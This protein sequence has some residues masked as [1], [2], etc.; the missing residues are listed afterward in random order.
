MPKELAYFAFFSAWGKYKYDL[1]AINFYFLVSWILLK[2]L[3]K[4]LNYLSK[5][6]KTKVQV[7][8]MHFKIYFYISY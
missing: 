7:I 4:A 3:I 8:F 1:M 2:F 5:K 6:I